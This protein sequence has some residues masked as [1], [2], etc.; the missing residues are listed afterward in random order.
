MDCSDLPCCL[1]ATERGEEKK[2]KRY[3]L[4]LTSEEDNEACL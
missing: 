1:Y 2:V 3:R 4:S